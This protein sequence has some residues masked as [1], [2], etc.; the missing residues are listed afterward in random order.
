MVEHT[1]TAWVPTPPLGLIHLP[2]IAQ[3]VIA[4]YPRRIDASNGQEEPQPQFN[5][6]NVPGC[7]AYLYDQYLW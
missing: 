5:L 3:E 4:W 2:V 7:I 1:S 6:E